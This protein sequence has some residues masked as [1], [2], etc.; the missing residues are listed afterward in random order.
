[1]EKGFEKLASFAI[2]LLGNSV[3]FAIAVCSVIFWLTNKQF[4]TQD[5]HA[6]VG[7]LIMG[8]GFLNLFIIQKSANRF[9]GSLHLKLNE[10]IA[11]HKF[12]RNALINAEEKTELEITLLSKEY[13][14]LVE[15][16]R[17]EEKANTS[18]KT[19]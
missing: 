14:I 10:L 18:T 1:M 16:E 6:I 13:T 5:V 15:K 11:S 9:A 3:T 7:D 17:A 12:A 19:I 8:I 2:F 4:Y